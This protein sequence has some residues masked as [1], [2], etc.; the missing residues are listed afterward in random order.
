MRLRTSDPTRCGTALASRSRFC[1]TGPMTTSCPHSLAAGLVC[2]HAVTVDDFTRWGFDVEHE[3]AD[4]ITVG[5]VKPHQ[6][7]H[8]AWLAGH[9]RIC[10]LD[11]RKARPH[12]QHSY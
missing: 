7:T 10:T 11:P 12:V 6:A 3:I 4:H 1:Y 5:T 9:V 8:A 2:S